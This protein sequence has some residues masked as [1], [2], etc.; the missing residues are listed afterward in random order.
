MWVTYKPDLVRNSVYQEY[1]S[2]LPELFPLRFNFTDVKRMSQ[3]MRNQPIT[4]VTVG[5]TVYVDLRYIKGH[6]V[7]DKLGLP[8][9]YFVQYVC[10]CKYVRWVGSGQKKIE[11]KCAVLD[12]L[13]R[14]WDSLDVYMFG[15]NKVLLPSM[16][17]VTERLCV[18]YPNILERHNRGKLLKRYA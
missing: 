10:E 15:S 9:A 1:V 16:T 14:N 18:Q 11:A 3:T 7:F 2:K 13:C 17:L 12:V 5:D 4:S 8:D 6:D